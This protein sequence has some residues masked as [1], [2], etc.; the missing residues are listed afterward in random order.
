MLYPPSFKN[1][2]RF[3]QREITFVTQKLLIPRKSSCN[4]KKKIPW[5][6]FKSW[7]SMLFVDNQN[8]TGWDIISWVTNEYYYTSRDWHENYWNTI[9]RVNRSCDWGEKTASTQ[10]SMSLIMSDTASL[11][12]LFYFTCNLEFVS[13][14]LQSSKQMG[15]I[16][17][18]NREE[19]LLFSMK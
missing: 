11:R 8:F 1:H 14:H 12:R 18:W 15:K 3:Q 10:L 16:S 13:C 5:N 7:R 19:T 9:V 2:K 6:H 4:L 17:Y